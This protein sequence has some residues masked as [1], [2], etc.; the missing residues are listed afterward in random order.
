MLKR[1]LELSEQLASQNKLLKTRYNKI[2]TLR[3]IS[4]AAAVISVG[5]S[6]KL[7]FIIIMIIALLYF[8]W[9]VKKHS[10]IENEMKFISSKERIVKFYLNRAD[11]QW[12]KEENDGEENNTDDFF[13]GHDL[14][15][16]GRASLYQFLC[17][18]DSDQGRKKLADRLI[19]GCGSI[20][21]IASEQEAVK[22]IAEKFD[23]RTDFQTYASSLSD[24]DRKSGDKLKEFADISTRDINVI[25]KYISFL[26]PAAIILMI[27][28][29]IAGKSI[30]LFLSGALI[31]AA[32][33]FVLSSLAN[34]FCQG[35]I[36][37]LYQI[38]NKISSY[39]KIISL[40]QNEKFKSDKLKQIKHKLESTDA[41]NQIN[42][43]LHISEL[44]EMR[45]NMIAYL[46]LNS[47]FM[48]DVHCL[49]MFCRWKKGNG[50]N[51]SAWIDAVAELEVVASLSVLPVVNPECVYPEISESEKPF[52]HFTD[53]RH[54]L[55]D[56]K[57]VV[58]NSADIENDTL[59]ITGSNM[60]GKTTFMRSIGLALVLANAGSPVTAGAF[61]ASYM[62]LMTSI[63]TQDSVTDGISTFY[64]EL[65]RI[66]Q[67]VD[68]VSQ[69]KPVIVLID[70]IF[71]GTNS[72][73]RIICAQETI[74]RLSHRNAIVIVTTHDFELCSSDF[75]QKEPVNKHFS[76]YYEDNKIKFD[77]KIMDGRCTT[78]NAQH[79]LKMIGITDD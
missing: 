74:K 79:L 43:L 56:R 22:E 44:S 38:N 35:T 2:S 19:S 46:V 73:D 50:E 33:A 48:W 20:D 58:G 6:R 78:T 40:I 11:R 49:S 55:I 64:A 75:G 36:R 70:E 16:F 60:S 1:Y 61:S 63:R 32:S 17:R 10:D 47:L 18:A 72:K 53:L 77:Y 66:K 62:T 14:D 24:K 52:V 8:V 42:A 59:I 23:F 5:V 69:G 67:M 3:L 25:L 12:T 54:T 76:E 65:L 31:F 13:A 57:S 9:L 41:F 7:P 4:V 37:N 39:S 29:L 68:F 30:V 34:A 51:I 15:I 27:I 45:S 71:K 21:K 26:V 28:F